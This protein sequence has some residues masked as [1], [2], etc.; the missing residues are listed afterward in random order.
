MSEGGLRSMSDCTDW[1]KLA[2]VGPRYFGESGR[3]KKAATATG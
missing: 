2:P 3:F 1:K